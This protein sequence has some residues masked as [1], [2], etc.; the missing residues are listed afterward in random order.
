MKS[1]LPLLLQMALQATLETRV[2]KLTL[3][4]CCRGFA[5]WSKDRDPGLGL[6]REARLQFCEEM[7]YPLR[8]VS[9]SG[10]DELQQQQLRKCC[11]TIIKTLWD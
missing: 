1:L 2:A 9:C 3:L 6:L 4:K 8:G 10:V 5:S 7:D 11:G